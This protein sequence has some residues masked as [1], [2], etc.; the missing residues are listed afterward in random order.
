VVEA[1]REITDG[2]AHLSLDA[3]GHSETCFNSVSC[4]RRRGRHV[5]VGLMLADHAHAKIPMAQVIGQ[6]LEIYGS[7]GMQAWRYD[8]MLAMILSGTLRP[9]RLLGATLS[10]EDAIPAL[11]GMDRQ[12]P[13]GITI[14][15]PKRSDA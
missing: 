1:V 12:A 2:G 14:I 5:Q 9:E 13:D 8:A 11:I 6:E 15:D 10:L 3:L 4:L 7:H